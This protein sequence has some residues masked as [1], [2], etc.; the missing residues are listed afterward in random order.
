VLGVCFI[1]ADIPLACLSYKN[2]MNTCK[3][4]RTNLILVTNYVVKYTFSWENFIFQCIL[5]LH[6]KI[7]P[8]VVVYIFGLIILSDKYLNQVSLLQCNYIF[9]Y[10]VILSNVLYYRVRIWLRVSC[11]QLCIIY[12]YYMVS[13]CNICNEDTVK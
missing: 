5:F 10:E 13:T 3:N 7:K 8:L 2:I 1:C 9:K 12:C 4:K 6:S 11:M